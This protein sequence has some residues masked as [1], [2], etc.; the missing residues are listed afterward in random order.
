MCVSESVIGRCCTHNTGRPITKS[1]KLIRLSY[2]LCLLCRLHRRVPEGS[3]VL[4]CEAHRRRFEGVNPWPLKMKAIYSLE[5]PSVLCRMTWRH[6]P[7]RKGFFKVLLVR[8]HKR[9]CQ[10]LL[11]ICPFPL[12]TFHIKSTMR[13]LLPRPIQIRTFCPQLKP[14]DI[15]VISLHS[16]D[17]I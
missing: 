14:S 6:I 9:C 13:F 11:T 16:C 8:D 3:S 4:Q 7:K 2:L 1:L 5:K 12:S 17:V 10:Y 15:T